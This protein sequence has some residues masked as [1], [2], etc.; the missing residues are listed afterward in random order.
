MQKDIGFFGGR[1]TKK[2][3]VDKEAQR[4]I[5]HKGKEFQIDENRKCST[6]DRNKQP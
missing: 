4:G 2:R 6:F 1:D 3:I 5:D